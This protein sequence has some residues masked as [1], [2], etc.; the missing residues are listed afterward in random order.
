[1]RGVCEIL[2]KRIPATRLFY[3]AK[4]LR[5]YDRGS[6]NQFSNSLLGFAG[7]IRGLFVPIRGKKI[8]GKKGRTGNNTRFAVILLPA[9]ILRLFER[10]RVFN[11]HKVLSGLAGKICE[12][13]WSFVPFRGQKNPAEGCAAGLRS[14]SQSQSGFSTA[15][16]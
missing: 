2:Q 14:N 7:K 11:N 1:M 12:F 13:L 4:P 15:G 8:A 6:L 5:L 16:D 3:P 10:G 9:K